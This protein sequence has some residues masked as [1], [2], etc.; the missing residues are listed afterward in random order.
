MVGPE[1]SYLGAYKLLLKEKGREG[2]KKPTRAPNAWC[3]TADLWNWRERA[4]AW[5]KEQLRQLRQEEER[6]RKRARDARLAILSGLKVKLSQAIL[7]LDPTTAGMREVVALTKLVLVEERRELG[8]D[9]TVAKNLNIDIGSLT[10]EQLE[11][12]AAGEDIISV[13]ADTRSS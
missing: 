3:V 6:G 2:P 9:V 4:D 7:N 10:D 5:D 11:R 12:L 13:L 1:R 8:Q